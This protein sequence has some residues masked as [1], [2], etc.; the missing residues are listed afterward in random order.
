MSSPSGKLSD[1][2]ASGGGKPDRGAAQDST[3]KDAADSGISQSQAAEETMDRDAQTSDGSDAGTE[4]KSAS[5]VKTEH[6]SYVGWYVLLGVVLAGLLVFFIKK[7][8]RKE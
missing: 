4:P 8:R 5:N 7:K 3:S 6:K 2:P 1:N